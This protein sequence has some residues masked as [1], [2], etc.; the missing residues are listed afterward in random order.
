MRGCF[1]DEG[2]FVNRVH[3]HLWHELPAWG[4]GLSVAHLFHVSSAPC[5]DTSISLLRKTRRF[6]QG[7]L[8]ARPNYRVS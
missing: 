1:V 8:V 7:G 2:L 5:L 3:W 6:S 4:K